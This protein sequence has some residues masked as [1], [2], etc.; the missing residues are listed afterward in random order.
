MSPLISTFKNV[1]VA[2]I[3]CFCLNEAKSQYIYEQ[4]YANNETDV[5]DW[6][7]VYKHPVRLV[8]AFYFTGRPFVIYKMDGDKDSLKVLFPNGEV[9]I[10]GTKFLA[11]RDKLVPKTGVWE[12]YHTNNRLKEHVEFR[13][14]KRY[15]EYLKLD[16]QGNV[17]KKKFYPQNHDFG[18]HIS[19]SVSNMSIESGKDTIM[20]AQGFGWAIGFLIDYKFKDWLTLRVL[21]TT[22]FHLFQIDVQTAVNRE[23]IT[24]GYTI[25]KLPVSG[26]LSI[27]KNFNFIIGPSFNHS[28]SD[29][30]SADPIIFSTKSFDLSADVG[31]SY[32]FDL[33]LFTIVPELRYSRQ[34]TNWADFKPIAYSSSVDRLIRNQLTFSLIFKG[35]GTS[36][37]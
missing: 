5:R 32:N 9:L 19:G 2:L 25:L 14:G 11:S 26:I 17:L 6:E 20:S 27:Y 37:W 36:D 1:F 23:S 28:I 34:L 7:H 29:G 16:D 35:T 33:P 4:G 30:A 3:I 22:S 21:P 15:G 8:N 24:K 13:K 10:K 18:F 31:V 12:V